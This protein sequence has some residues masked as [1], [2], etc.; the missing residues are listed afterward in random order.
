MCKG[1][2]PILIQYTDPIERPILVFGPKAIVLGKSFKVLKTNMIE[3]D[4]CDG[5]GWVE[6]GKQLKTTCHRC[7]G[8]GV[9]SRGE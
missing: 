3:C 4:Y 5:S 1:Y 7:D 8:Y 2:F 6:G 9:I